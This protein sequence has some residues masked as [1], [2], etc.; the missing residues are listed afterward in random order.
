LDRIIVSPG[1]LPAVEDFLYQQRFILEG[2]GRLAWAAMGGSFLAHGL[3]CTQ[4][5]PTPNMSV[6]VGSGAIYLQSVVD[7][8]SYGALAPDTTHQIIKQGILRDPATI[9]LTAPTTVGQSINYLIQGGL[10]EVDGD[11]LVLPF[12]NVDNPAQPL[13][14]PD[15]LGANVNTTR[16]NVCS[17]N[18]KPGTAATTGTQTTPAPDTGYQGLYV[19]T[20]AYGAT[21][22]VNGNIAPVSPNPFLRAPNAANAQLSPWISATDTGSANAAVVTLD[23]VPTS[24]PNLLNVKKIASNNTGA[25]TISVNG[26]GAVAVVGKT[27]SALGSGDWPAS[28]LRLL[29]WNGTAYQII[30]G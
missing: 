1:A 11:P 13:L 29:A 2:L 20:V 19:V 25:M 22:V 18:A 7:Q 28:I 4:Q 21:S 15:G 24:Y 9:P 5:S 23:P 16:R 27:G 3:A 30:G 14:G 8:T 17:V 26:M 12:Y 6:L 10:T